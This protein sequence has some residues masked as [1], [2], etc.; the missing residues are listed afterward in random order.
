MS[1]QSETKCRIVMLGIGAVGK[2]AISIQFV[3]GRFVLDYDPTIASNYSRTAK[4]DNNTVNIEIFDTAGME[5]FNSV[6]NSTI[7]NGDAFII[8]YDITDK[9]SFDNVI[10]YHNEVIQAKNADKVPCVLCGNKCDLSDNR[11][12]AKADGEKLAK[13]MNAIFFET[14]AKTNTNVFQA[15]ESAVKQIWEVRNGKKNSDSGNK[16]KGLCNIL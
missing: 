6:M 7:R 16:K 8:I 9:S 11:Q 14:S 10:N 12:V 5:T 3:Q 13:S 4:I 2:S 15:F 1:V